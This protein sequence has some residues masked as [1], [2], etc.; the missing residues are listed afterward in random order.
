MLISPDL[1]YSDLIKILT[2]PLDFSGKVVNFL[3]GD[4]NCVRVL[5]QSGLNN[6]IFDKL[7]LI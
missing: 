1:R 7:K 2:F 5:P 3:I 6:L 4:L